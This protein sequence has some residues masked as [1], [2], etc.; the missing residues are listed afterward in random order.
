MLNDN[1]VHQKKTHIM[2]IVVC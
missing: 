1:L 2:L